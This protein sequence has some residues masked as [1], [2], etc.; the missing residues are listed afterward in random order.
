MRRQAA[1][2]AAGES[3]FSRQLLLGI[4]LTSPATGSTER[5]RLFIPDAPPPPSFIFPVISDS[6]CKK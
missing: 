5:I 6:P 2:V 1:C 3:L 4:A